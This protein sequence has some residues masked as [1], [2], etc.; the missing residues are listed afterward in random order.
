MIAMMIEVENRALDSKSQSKFK[1]LV[2]GNIS[3]YRMKVYK[4]ETAIACFYRAE[5]FRVKNGLPVQ[6]DAD[7]P[8]FSCAS[9]FSLEKTLAEEQAYDL[10]FNSILN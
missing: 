3:E 6:I 4:F 9:N 10:L 8:I 2:V 1:G 7:F 5:I